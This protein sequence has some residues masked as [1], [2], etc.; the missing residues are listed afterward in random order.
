MLLWSALF[1]KPFF[2]AQHRLD[3][4]LEDL[5]GNTMN[6]LNFYSNK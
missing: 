6:V 4:Y 1:N 5:Q 3:K 2:H